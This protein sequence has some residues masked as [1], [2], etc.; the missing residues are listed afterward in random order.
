[1]IRLA[2]GL[3]A[4]VLVAACG[5]GAD[6]P[7]GHVWRDGA[8]HPLTREVEPTRP[9]PAHLPDFP[10]G[11]VVAAASADLD[12]DGTAEIVVSYRHPART[13]PWD[14]APLP[15]D[16]SGR[17]AHL[18]VIAAD[19]AP[20]WLAHRIPRPVGDLAVC[21]DAVLLGYTG[22]ED[23]TIVGVAVATWNGFGFWVSDQIPG[24][25]TIGCAD[26]DGDGITEAVA[27]RRSPDA[28]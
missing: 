19:G 8:W 27:I 9:E 12:G 4:A 16:D 14:P 20:I 13:V 23:D 7:S 11:E 1:M 24:S 18:G 3:A 25:A 2:S 6:A 10:Y 26:A 21:G 17:S 22:F 28:P 5:T 15:T